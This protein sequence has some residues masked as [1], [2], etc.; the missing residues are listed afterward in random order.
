M[1]GPLLFPHRSK[2][3][4]SVS[5]GAIQ[6][7]MEPKSEVPARARTPPREKNAPGAPV[8]VVCDGFGQELRDLAKAML[9]AT[10]AIHDSTDAM[11]EFTK[12]LK[13]REKPVLRPPDHPPPAKLRKV[14]ERP[15]EAPEADKGKSSSSKPQDDWTKP[16]LYERQHLEWQDAKEE[17]QGC[18]WRCQLCNKWATAEHFWGEPHQ[19]AVKKD[20]ADW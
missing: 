17:G 20:K 12:A 18:G 11:K 14:E 8:L 4:V 2:H 6:A 13:A 16:E 15:K 5:Q 3:C 9:K 19:R 10:D 7:A 1:M